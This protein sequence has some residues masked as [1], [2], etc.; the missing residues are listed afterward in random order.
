MI[1]QVAE[2]RHEGSPEDGRRRD[3]KHTRARMRCPLGEEKRASAEHQGDKGEDAEIPDQRRGQEREEDQ[4]QHD[5]VGV[6]ATDPLLHR[7][8]S[9][10]PGHRRPR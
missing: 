3:P 10:R 6:V 4:Q 9:A 1:G 2:N 8:P 5:P 7:H